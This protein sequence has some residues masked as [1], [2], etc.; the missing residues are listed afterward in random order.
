MIQDLITRARLALEEI[1][2]RSRSFSTA[3]NRGKRWAPASG[4][5]A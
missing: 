3:Y 2:R 1:P 4:D 5:A